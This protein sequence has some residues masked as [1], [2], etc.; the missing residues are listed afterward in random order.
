VNTSVRGEYPIIYRLVEE[1]G[2]VAEE[3]NRTVIVDDPEVL[4]ADFTLLE[5]ECTSW[6][7][8]AV[9]DNY[10]TY[11]LNNNDWGRGFLNE[12]EEGVQC[13]FTVEENGSVKG[14]WYWG[15]PVG[16]GWGLVKGYPEGIYGRK[17]RTQYNPESGLPAKYS[18]IS[19]IAIDLAYR[20]YNLTGKYN[21]ALESWLHYDEDTSMDNIRYEVMIRFDPDGFHPSGPIFTDVLIDGIPYDLYETVVSETRTFYNFVAK[22]KVR[23]LQFDMKHFIDFLRDQVGADDM[24]DLYFADVEMGVEVIAGSGLLLLD[25][26]HVEVDYNRPPTIE[27]NITTTVSQYGRYRFQPTASDPDGDTLTFFIINK[28]EWATFESSTGLLYGVPLS[29]GVEENITIGVSD[30]EHNVTL[31]PFDINITEPQN[32]AHLYGRATQPPNLTGIYWYRDASYTI[33]ENLSTFN[34]TDGNDSLNWLEI[35]L[36][37]GTEIRE[38]VIYNYDDG[39]D[40]LQRLEGAGLYIQESSLNGDLSNLQPEAQIATLQGVLEQRISNDGNRSGNYIII[41]AIDNNPLNLNE[42]VVFGIL[43]EAPTPL[44]RDV[45]LGARYTGTL[46]APV[47]EI[48]IVDFQGDPLTFSLTPTDTP[49]TIDGEGL[50]TLVQEPERESYDLNLTVTDGVESLTL[51]I[52]VVVARC[53]GVAVKRWEGIEGTEIADFL[54]FADTE[55]NGTTF[56]EGIDFYGNEADN[57]AME[58]DAFLI[59]EESGEYQFVVA[60]DDETLLKIWGNGI[61]EE[62][63][64]PSYTSYQN[65]DQGGKSGWLQLEAGHLYHIQALLKEGGGAEHISVAWQKRGET[66]FTPLPP[67]LLYR[68]DLSGECTLCPSDVVTE[69]LTPDHL[70]GEFATVVSAVPYQKDSDGNYQYDPRKLSVRFTRNGINF[71]GCGATFSVSDGVVYDGNGTSGWDGEAEAIWVA[72]GEEGN[73]TATI[74]TENGD[75]YQVTAEI[76]PGTDK[77]ANSIHFWY[78]FGGREFTE[79]NITAIPLTKPEATYYALLVWRGAYMGIQFADENRTLVIFSVWDSDEGEAAIIDPGDSNE[80]SDFGGEGTGVGTRLK[81]PADGE[82]YPEITDGEGNLLLP[83]D[84]QLDV[85]NSYTMHIVVTY[86]TSDECEETNST[87]ECVDYRVTFYDNTN[88]YGPISLGTIRCPYIKPQNIGDSFVEDWLRSPDDNCITAGRRT[89]IY[90]D[91]AF[92]DRESGEWIEVGGGTFSPGYYPAGNEICANYTAKAFDGGILMSSG[93]W[94]LEYMEKP[95]KVFPDYTSKKVQFK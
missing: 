60:G 42:V 32:I 25:R 24:D 6:S 31:P 50:L 85:N 80:Q 15:W 49:F 61:D 53:N 35:A 26:F 21:I 5:R 93:G 82:T 29:P 83:H 70:Y 58:F 10:S 41:K 38:I 64:G 57:F 81:F 3:L 78:D 68:P 19:R 33:D 27:G 45:E 91:I 65:W 18:D 9:D 77:H 54:P 8:I 20:D 12:G 34:I 11:T 37:E 22:R 2:S 95:L 84:Y 63:Y 48:G 71:K 67:E 39:S 40:S 73:Q 28:P 13:I 88:G 56:M 76:V 72:G 14:G 92:K 23:E 87:S 90:R 52:R 43:P 59:P 4:V 89:V 69:L 46:P 55:A 86:P 16:E 75:T 62:V 17:F 94:D 74:S 7:K 51:P 1:N 30:G 47:G 36:P 44:V 66:T 79:F